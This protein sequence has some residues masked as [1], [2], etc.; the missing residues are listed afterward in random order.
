MTMSIE[1]PCRMLLSVIEILIERGVMVWGDISVDVVRAK[2]LRKM[3]DE[4]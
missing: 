4:N 2:F 3:V 1:E